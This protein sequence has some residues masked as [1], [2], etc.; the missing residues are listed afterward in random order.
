MDHITDVPLV[1][2]ESDHLDLDIVL[3]EMLK[4]HKVTYKEGWT[5]EISEY[6][7]AIGCLRIGVPT[8]DSITGMPTRITHQIRV[9]P[10]TVPNGDEGYVRRWLFEQLVNVEKHE[11]MEFFAIDGKAPFFPDHSRPYE[12]REKEEWRQ[13]T[14]PTTAKLEP[15]WGAER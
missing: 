9:P 14:T 6:S 10:I 1:R 15:W 8:T 3:A 5:I 11:A 13:I 12:V 4:R 7:P 2:F